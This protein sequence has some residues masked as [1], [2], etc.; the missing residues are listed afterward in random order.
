[1]AENKKLLQVPPGSKLKFK[2]IDL[3]DAELLFK[4][5]VMETKNLITKI[6]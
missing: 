2:E 3:A 4:L 5:Y 1:M 6:K